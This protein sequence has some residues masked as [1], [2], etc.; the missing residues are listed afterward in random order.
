M[1]SKSTEVPGSVPIVD[2]TPFTTGGTLEAQKKTARELAEKASQNG[3]IGISGHNVPNQML[4][5]AFAMTKKLFDLPY[6]SKMKAPHPAGPTPHRGYSGTGRE[7]AA[8]KTE[9]EHWEGTAK[10]SDYVESTD[11]KE[12]YEIGSDENKA[13]YNIWLPEEVFPGFREWGLRFYWELNQAGSA[14]FEALMMSLELEEREMENVRGLHSGHDNQL[15]LL[16]YPP[17]EDV[18]LKSGNKHRLGAH[19]DWR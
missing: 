2:I 17:V 3:C 16:H 9:T 15:R 19:T 5:E 10:A 7:N 6:E 8:R 18:R 13:E 11:Y 1:D 14:I 4:S 12:S